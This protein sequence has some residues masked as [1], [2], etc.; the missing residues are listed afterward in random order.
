MHYK[1]F[2]GNKIT[3]T[4]KAK[5]TIGRDRPSLVSYKNRYIFLS[6]GANPQNWDQCYKS[7]DYYDITSDSWSEAPSLRK[8]RSNHSSCIHG[9]FIYVFCGQKKNGIL[10]DS[11]ERLDAQ[12]VITGNTLASWDTV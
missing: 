6:G 10:S 3:V 11:I 1:G 8:A 7:V 5:P 2:D 9:D 12:G 4:E